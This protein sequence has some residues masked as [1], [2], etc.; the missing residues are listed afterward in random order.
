VIRLLIVDDHAVVREGLRLLFATVPDVEVVGMAADGAVAVELARGLAPDVV[1]MDLGMPKL[2]GIEATR[3]I[4][5][6][7]RDAKV[8]VLTSY[9]DEER[10]IAALR[11]GAI[12]YVLKHSDAAEVIRAV[13]AAYVGE[14][15]L[16]PAAGGVLAAQ[17]DC[18][19]T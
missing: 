14:R 2:D 6:R 3:R 8:V 18:P 1:L 17:E 13:R 19:P 15:V 12:S 16:D 4:V 9:S 5:A 10:M 7:D 11:A